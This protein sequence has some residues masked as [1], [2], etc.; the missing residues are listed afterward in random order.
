M[1]RRA[2]P[3]SDQE[4]EAAGQG[5]AHLQP[6]V[7]GGVGD[8]ALSRRP[9]APRGAGT[10]WEPRLCPLGVGSQ[11]R[12]CSH[13]P[14]RSGDVFVGTG[15][16]GGRGS[17]PNACRAAL[18]KGEACCAGATHPELGPRDAPGCLGAAAARCLHT[19]CR[20]ACA[21]W[22][23]IKEGLGCGLGGP[24]LEPSSRPAVMQDLR[25]LG[26]QQAVTAPGPRSPRSPLRT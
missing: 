25:G 15:R 6:G 16:L 7:R 3:K 23:R 26:G 4:R 2:V 21:V 20:C 22:V 18:C 12:P 1:R 17:R 8:W 11:P 10:D 19:C 24:S 5:A 9:C 13:V 14:E